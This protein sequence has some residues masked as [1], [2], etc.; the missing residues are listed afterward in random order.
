MELGV[1]IIKDVQ[2]GE[3]TSISDNVLLVN[4][5]ELVTLLLDDGRLQGME[6]EIAR[7]G[8]SERII[9]VLDVIEPR[10]KVEGSGEIFPGMIGGRER[11]GDGKTHVLRGAAV[12][13][14]GQI[15]AVPEAIVDMSGPAAELVPFA[16]TCN[17]VLIPQF[18]EGLD[19]ID[20]AAAIKMA[21][22]KAAV[23]MAEASRDL[24]PDETETYDLPPL[25]DMD[26]GV[27]SLPRIAY[28]YQLQSQ[29]DLCEPFVYGDNARKLLPTLLHPNELMDGAV[30][31]GNYEMPPCFKNVT[32]THQNNPVVQSLYTR[33]GQDLCFVGVIVE[34]EHSTLL[35]K[36]RS[37]AMAA[38]LAKDILGADGVIITKEGGGHADTDL[39]LNCQRCEEAGVKTVLVV[40]E[41]AGPDGT[42]QPLSDAS[43]DRADAF[44]STGNSNEPIELPAV[45]R[46]I[47]GAALAGIDLPPEGAL[48]V[49]VMMIPSATSQVGFTRLTTV[50]L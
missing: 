16:R 15:P 17:L 41:P 37:A 13:E 43:S 46:V 14:T 36:E 8:E 25:P 5:E 38:K 3:D 11:V 22:L 39:M 31:S 48:T 10:I 7:P 21:G 49:P 26:E 24:K 4:K 44:V 19:R 40:D 27:R 28:I 20:C 30:V 32:F 50:E 1:F 42:A 29:A 34:N 2:F 23:Y 47:G 6:L 33:H 9:H 45:D 18:A 35:D 12:V